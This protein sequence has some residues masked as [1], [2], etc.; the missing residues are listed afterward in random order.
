MTNKFHSLAN[1]YTY[2]QNAKKIDLLESQIKSKEADALHFEELQVIYDL[3]GADYMIED[4]AKKCNQVTK[5]V[6]KLKIQKN[7]VEREMLEFELG[8]LEEN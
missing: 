3:M 4:A 2:I 7:Q 1:L 8:T 5:E 6:L